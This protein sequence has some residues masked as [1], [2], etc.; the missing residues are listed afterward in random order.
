MK[1]KAKALLFAVAFSSLAISGCVQVSTRAN[2]RKVAANGSAIVT[3][4]LS[5]FR[6]P[7]AKTEVAFEIVDGEEC[8]VLSE[9][10]KPTDEKGR[11]TVNFRGSQGVE[12]CTA[13]IQASAQGWSSETYVTVNPLSLPMVKI[14][15]VSA[16]A[17]VLIASFAIDRI[18]RGLLF[19][20]SFW[21]RW[22]TA[23]PN[24]D[25]PE[26][27]VQA[28]KKHRLAYFGFAGLF[29]MVALG[30]YGRVQILSAMGFV[31][32]SPILDTILTGLLLMGGADRTEAILKRLGATGE[33]DAA[34]STPI[35][36][37]GRLVLDEGSRKPGERSPGAQDAA[38][39][40]E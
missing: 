4:K 29:G 35:Q 38:S 2:P 19:M 30:W 5:D 33:E 17:V 34:T 37:T 14:D 3:A 40:G 23:F 16:I 32:V 27:P 6:A 13:T 25:D 24:P 20:L 26:T 7:L 31:G 10:S 15:G 39:T 9:A 18:V 21:K 28:R 12:D 36:I 1:T 8:G 11:V 22:A